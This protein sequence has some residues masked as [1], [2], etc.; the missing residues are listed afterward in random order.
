[1]PS[2]DETGGESSKVD[3]SVIDDDEIEERLFNKYKQAVQSSLR[4]TGGVFIAGHY[5]KKYRD[6][7]H[8]LFDDMLGAPPKTF[9]HKLERSSY[10]WY[11]RSKAKA[12]ASQSKDDSPQ[13]QSELPVTEAPIRIPNS[14]EE[15]KIPDFVKKLCKFFAEN[16]FYDI[17]FIDDDWLTDSI[18]DQLTQDG[19]I[20]IGYKAC[21]CKDLEE[22][23]RIYETCIKWEKIVNLSW[24]Y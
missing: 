11:L 18:L 7:I 17:N 12:K 21:Y 19:L 3:Q 8:T 4:N 22:K 13:K 1:M 16:G 2:G 5:F 15:T 6:R 20:I 23:Q 9:E 14:L 24:D 10:E